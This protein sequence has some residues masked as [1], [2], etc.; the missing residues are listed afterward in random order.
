MQVVTKNEMYAIDRNAMELGLT[1]EMLMENAGQAVARKLYDELTHDDRITIIIGKGN[2]G[3]DGFVVARMLKSKGYELDVWLAVEKEAVTGDAEKAMHVYE[4]SGFRMRLLNEENL[5]AL[6]DSLAVSTVIIDS[7]L[8]IGMKGKLR[9]PYKEII[10][11]VNRQKHAK[12]LAIDLPSGLPADGGKIDDAIRADKTFVIHLPKVGAFMYPSREYYGELDVV[13]IGIPPII[14]KKSAEKRFVWMPEDVIR[15]FPR[16]SPSSHKSSHGKGLIVAGSKTMSG[17]AIMAARAA[18]RSGSGLL[19]VAMPEEARLP[20]ASQVIEA[21]YA[22]CPSHEGEFAGTLPVQLNFDAIAVGPGIGRGEGSRRIVEI[23]LKVEA[24]L[25]IDADG[26]FHLAKMKDQL[27]NRK[28]PTV[29][30]PHEGEMARL[31]G[32]PVEEVANNRFHLSKQF[33][34]EHGVHL[35][36]KGPFTICTTPAGEQYI[37]PTGN[38]ALAK[39]GSGDVLT[40]IILALMMQQKSLQEAISN[41][42]FVHGK[43]ADKLISIKH[44]SVDVIASDVIESLPI[45]YKSIENRSL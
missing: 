1:G 8:G 27:K 4:R 37:N 41:A 39:G 40:G 24:P 42:A 22:P 23:L 19:T 43:T 44:S 32:L 13:D 21:M 17:A 20:I 18:L 28:H 34:L 30:T 45:V 31:L 25:L 11:L 3:G 16:R 9:S 10:T 6:K 38:A 29:L 5:N 15:T 26:L 2:N 36:L 14:N 35:I 7:L 12:R 33:A